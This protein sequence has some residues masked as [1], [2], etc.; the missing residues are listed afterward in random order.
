MMA[1]AKLQKHALLPPRSPFPT[2]AA[3]PSPYADHVLIARPQGSSHHRHA[4]GHGHGH[5]Q[6]TSSESFIEEQPSWLEDLL[7]EPET[8]VRQHGRAGHRRSSSD[9]FALFD[10]GAAGAGAYANGFEGI[11]GGGGQS[12][13]WGGVH[14]YYAKPGSFG[15]PQGR[16]WEQ[17]MPNL[18]GYRHGGGPPMLAKEKVGG[19]HGP[20]NAL[21]DHDHGMDKRAPDEAEHD[22]K[23][24]ANEG[25]PPKH[26]QLE[27]DNKRAKQQYAQRSRV[28]KLQYIA[29]LERKVQALQS[30]G[31]EVS[32]EV[33]FRTQ[34]N[35]MLDLENKA[36]KQR[37]ESLAQEQLIKRLQ[38]EMF[39]REIGRLRSL[40]QQQQHAPAHGHTNS[41]DL[42]SQFANLS[43]KH[44]DPN[45]RGDASGSLRT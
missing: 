28:R 2:A 10:G 38:Q 25:V 31:I 1:N 12:V 4:H 5:H 34:Q 8:P 40:Y 7:D 44:K 17:G 3:A 20:P 22:Q 9:S 43:L 33:E 18:V 16:P 41:R 15:R 27:A 23:V 29:E 26:V 30:E 45:S 42:D 32:A 36:L 35:I 6:R 11:G 13:P 14:E 21:R 24:G 37:L 39:E 19:H